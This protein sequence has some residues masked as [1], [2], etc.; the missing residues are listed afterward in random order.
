MRQRDVIAY[1]SL[2]LIWGFSFLLLIRVVDAF[3]WVGAVTLRSFAVAALLWSAAHITRRRLDFGPW[4]HLAVVGSTTVA[5]QLIGLSYASPR[6]GTAMAAIFV[7][8][9]PLFTAGFGFLLSAER[10]ER[11]RLWGLLLGAIGMVLLVGF[12][13][14]AIDAT[15]LVG[16]ASMLASACAA[17]YGSNYAQRRLVGVGSWEQTIGAFFAAGV[18]TAPLLLLVPVPRVLRASDWAFLLALAGVCSALAYVLYFR[19]VADVGA[20]VAISVE[21]LVTV[22]AV[23]V[24][25]L[26]LHERLSAWQLA[27]GAV[28]VAGCTLVLGLLPRRATSR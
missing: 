12:P 4:R 20:T 5:V 9:I 13:A 6:I 25:A 21:F 24:G 14:H 17:A 16:C 28:I 3:G 1:A 7:A 8:T 27:G 19:L 18:L 2:A 10:L 26:V 11:S 23:A 15:F 22:I